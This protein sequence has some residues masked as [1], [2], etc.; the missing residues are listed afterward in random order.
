MAEPSLWVVTVPGEPRPHEV[1]AVT[2]EQALDFVDA[3]LGRRLRLRANYL[4]E[5]GEV[6]RVLVV[7]GVVVAP[8][9]YEDAAA[10]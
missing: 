7:N 1:L 9:I 4:G 8:M 6:W 3:K 10:S 2:I 5:P